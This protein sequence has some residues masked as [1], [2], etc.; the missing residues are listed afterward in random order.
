MEKTSKKKKETKKIT[1]RSFIKKSTTL[2]LGVYATASMG[3]WF[4]KDALSSSGNLNLFTWPDYSKPEVIAAF[5]KSTGIKVKV[6]NYATNQECMNK[7]RASRAR[8]FDIAQP[9]LTE[10]KLHMDFDLYQAMDENKITNLNNL[11]PSFYESSAKLGGVIRGQRVGMPYN[12][13]T[14]GITFNTDKL[15]YKYG[16]LSYGHVGT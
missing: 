16:D 3:P 12:W 13:G 7:L 11:E 8:G 10:Y 6:T 15:D 5:E 4:I 9:S 1:R 14:E 2:G